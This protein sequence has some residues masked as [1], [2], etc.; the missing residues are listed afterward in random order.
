MKNLIIIAGI[1][2]IVILLL[3]RKPLIAAVPTVLDPR[4][5]YDGNVGTGSI[6]IVDNSN[7]YQNQFVGGD[8]GP[9]TTRS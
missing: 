4:M 8:P 1:T 2:F 5:K 3:R 6:T 9:V 7:G